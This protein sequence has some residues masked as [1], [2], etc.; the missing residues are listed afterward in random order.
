M[1][2]KEHVPTAKRGALE[3]NIQ[4]A[5]KTELAPNKTQKTL[6]AKACGVSRFA[7]NW[8]LAWMENVYVHN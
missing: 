7:Y 3:V 8:G 1:S 2:D 5:Y 6:L 4:R